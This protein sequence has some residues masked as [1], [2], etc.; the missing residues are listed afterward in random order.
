MEN[1]KAPFRKQDLMDELR[2]TLFVLAKE[3]GRIYDFKNAPGLL[4]YSKETCPNTGCMNEELRDDLDISGYEVTRFMS[5]LYDYGINGILYSELYDEWEVMEEDIK[6]FFDGL[7]DFPLLENNAD[8]SLDKCL[9][10]IDLSHLRLALD[11]GAYCFLDD[12]TA[13][14]AHIALKDLARL[15]GIDEK[16]IRNLANPKS[17][18]PLMTVKHGSRTFVEIDVARNWLKQRGFKET[19]FRSR[20]A[21]RDLTTKRFLSKTDL[22][23][24]VKARRDQLQRSIEEVVRALGG[25]HEAQS[26]LSLLEK[27]ELPFDAAFFS[28]L[29]KALELDPRLFVMAAL[30][31][32]QREEATRVEILLDQPNSP[33]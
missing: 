6:G 7:R 19:E 14:W 3:L 8:Y 33:F 18:N 2:N 24:Y 9:E 1:R 22:G 12:G 11:Y 10:V 25:D 17:K 31:L 5:D 32:H 13:L 21:E 30:Q 28:N 26:K 23:A 15:A 20:A 29:A 4:G 27:G 16:T